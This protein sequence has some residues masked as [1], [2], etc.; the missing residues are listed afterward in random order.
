MAENDFEL[1]LQHYQSGRLAEAESACGEILRLFP[2]HAE[3]MHLLGIVAS[4]QGRRAEGIAFLQK[5]V[6]LHPNRADF[7]HNLGFALAQNG[8]MD[9]A[10][11][12]YQLATQL[13]PDFLDAWNNLA[14]A[15][16]AAGRRPELVNALRKLASL[17]PS[18]EIFYNLGTT[19]LEQQQDEETIGCLRKAIQLRPDFPEALNN[20]ASALKCV[21][22]MD[23]ALSYLDRAVSLSPGDAAIHGNKLY[24]QLFL[25]NYDG[26]AILEAHQ[27]W[28]R[29]HAQPL[30]NPRQTYSNDRNPDRVL[31]IG[32][33]SPD[34][35][36]HIIGRNILPLVRDRDPKRT[37]I[38]CYSSSNRTDRFTEQFQAYADGWRDILGVAD[39]Q[40]AEMIRADHIDILVDL[41]LHLKGSRLLVF[42]RKPAPVQATFAGY[43]GTTGL[44]AI[45]FRLTDPYLDPQGSNDA[46][47]S[48]K[49]IRLPHSFWCYD[50]RAMELAAGPGVNP[51]PAIANGYITFGCLNNFCKVNDLTLSLWAR[52]LHGTKNS[53]LVLLCPMGDH[54]KR[55]LERLNLPADR[56]E[57]VTTQ[58]RKIYLQTYHR[59]DLGLDT[60]PYNGH[61]TSL[62]SLWMGVP[63]VSLMGKTVVSRAGFS[64]SSNLGLA[65][66]L[67]AK[68]ADQFVE[69]TTLLAANPARLSELRRTLRHRMEKSPLM[70][71]KAFARDVESA[72]RQM[73]RQWC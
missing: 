69:I 56:V 52:V 32:Y 39:E 17:Q 43:P 38:F 26:T 10:I 44:S 70:N 14:T 29:I 24:V 40:V 49:S 54:R 61:T 30:C 57:F 23:E 64:Q 22:Q 55:V 35:G 12:E 72:Y 13:Q 8:Q 53:R 47:Y 5:A 66:E 68:T 41:S 65:D 67:V 9:L 73:F 42:A 71:S 3:A 37:E 2:G 60:F 50:A 21:G 15:A 19:L 16:R 33:V 20:L 11:G 36:E 45:D 62:D 59:I 58:E 28:D 46:Y 34:F 48:E 6:E 31:R 51:L 18:A 25:P 7:H 1:A 63:V 27:N 4:S